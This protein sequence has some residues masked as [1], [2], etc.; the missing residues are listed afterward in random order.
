[1]GEDVVMKPRRKTILLA[2][3]HEDVLIALEKLLEDAGF[4]TAAVWTAREALRLVDA[5]AFDLAL[6]N[7]YLPDGECGEV[8]KAIQNRGH[9]TLCIVMQPNAPEFMDFVRFGA[10]GATDIV[11]K[12]RFRQIV[13]LV[14]ECL[15]G[16]RKQIP[17]A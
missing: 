16:E 11:C 10:W 9:H 14:R 4:E 1:L 3:C 13:D 12:R 8:L 6:V 15:A 7:E 2:D 17:A 5:I